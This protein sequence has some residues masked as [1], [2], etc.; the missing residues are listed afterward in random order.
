MFAKNSIPFRWD[1]HTPYMPAVS[2]LSKYNN[3]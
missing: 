1:P 3:L 2:D